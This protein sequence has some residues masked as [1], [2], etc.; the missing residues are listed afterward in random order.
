[1]VGMNLVELL[2]VIGAASHDCR[3]SALNQWCSISILAT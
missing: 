3:A 1:M 2:Y